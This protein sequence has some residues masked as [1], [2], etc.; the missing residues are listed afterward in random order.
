MKIPSG[1]N[2]NSHTA[3]AVRYKNKNMRTTGKG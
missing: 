2:A 1:F 3:F